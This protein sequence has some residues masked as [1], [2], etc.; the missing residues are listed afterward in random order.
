MR[1]GRAQNEGREEGRTDGG[2]EWML[3]GQVDIRHDRKLH[4]AP[5]RHFEA[6]SPRVLLL[7][8]ICLYFASILIPFFPFHR[9]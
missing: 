5:V 4:K 9:R 1:E 8:N 3:G 6:Q 2:R 7:R